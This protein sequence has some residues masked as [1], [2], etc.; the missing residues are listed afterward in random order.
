MEN[1]QDYY[2][3]LDLDDIYPDQQLWKTVQKPSKGVQEPVQDVQNAVQKPFLRYRQ[4]RA[5]NVRERS[6]NEKAARNAEN[7]RY[8]GLILAGFVLGLTGCFSETLLHAD[9]LLQICSYLS[10]LSYFFALDPIRALYRTV[11]PQSRIILALITAAAIV[12]II[13]QYQEYII[14]A[15]L[16]SIAGLFAIYKCNQ[17]WLSADNWLMSSYVQRAIRASSIDTARIDEVWQAYGR[18]ECSTLLY[19]M[20]YEV[21]ELDRIHRATWL[22]GWMRGFEKTAKY[23]QR[24]EA[25]EKL[26]ADYKYLKADYNNLQKQNSETEKTIKELEARISEDS[27]QYA[28]IQKLYNQV[29]KENEQLLAANQEL[30]DE[31]I[32]ASATDPTPPAGTGQPDPDP[33]AAATI[34][35]GKIIQL[36]RKTENLKEKSREEKVL[37]ALS[38]GMSLAEAGKFAGCSKSTAYNIQKAHKEATAAKTKK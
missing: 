10:I 29:K 12:G 31:M 35:P 14:I 23:Q 34:P 4:H 38:A 24:M 19:E 8:G 5:K 27:Y 28:Q 36:Q 11:A 7:V 21:T 26:K 22:C 32:T 1:Y 15:S 25:A 18:R 37:E 2:A 20:G 16:L 13:C 30:I 6:I 9:P 33:A 3:D 17:S